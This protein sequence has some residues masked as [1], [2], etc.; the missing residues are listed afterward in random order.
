MRLW[1]A[2]I[3]R[4]YIPGRNFPERWRLHPDI[5]ANLQ[6]GP[7]EAST[8]GDKNC[9]RVYR[10]IASQP[11]LPHYHTPDASEDGHISSRAIE[12]TQGAADLD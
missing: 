9:T 10:M 4:A 6:Q 1:H 3:S 11:L 8:R 5:L 7:Y 12:L 2:F